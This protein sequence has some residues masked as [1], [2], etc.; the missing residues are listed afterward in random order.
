MNCPVA[1]P[2]IISVKLL[3]WIPKPVLLECT[4]GYKH[5]IVC[6][7]PETE[8]FVKC[9]RSKWNDNNV[10]YTRNILEIIDLFEPTQV[11]IATFRIKNIF[12]CINKWLHQKQESPEIVCSV[13]QFTEDKQEGLLE[14]MYDVVQSIRERRH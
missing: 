1:C 6:I 2:A 13:V 12:I 8:H 5:L 10:H 3:G 9:I 7:E 14:E 11:C 4:P